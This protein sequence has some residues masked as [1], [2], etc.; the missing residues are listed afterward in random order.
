MALLEDI[1]LPFWMAGAEVTKLA[2]AAKQWFELVLGWAIWPAQQMDARTCSELVLDLLAW[3]RDISR[4]SSEP[5][6]LYRLRVHY[7]YINAKDAGSKAGFA[8]ILIRLGVGYVEQ[9]ERMPGVDWDIIDIRL[10]DSQLSENQE[11]LTRLIEKYGR[12]CRRYRWSIIV[13]AVLEV[14]THGFGCD[15]ATEYAAVPPLTFGP[16]V[17]DFGCSSTTEIATA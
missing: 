1:T 3:G 8:R 7:A 15:Y 16:R 5:L 13:P 4:F 11:L 17:H 14:R 10:S 9:D 12:T 2:N 6:W